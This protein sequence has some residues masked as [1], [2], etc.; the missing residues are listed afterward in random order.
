MARSE[1][2]RLRRIRAGQIAR[3]LAAVERIDWS[4]TKKLFEEEK[5]GDFYRVGP[6]LVPTDFHPVA[7]V[8]VRG[9]AEQAAVAEFLQHAVA[10][11]RALLNAST[12]SSSSPGESEPR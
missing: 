5:Y 11:M 9:A 2:F 3:R 10:D 7:D 6:V 12:S 8:D 1:T 4:E